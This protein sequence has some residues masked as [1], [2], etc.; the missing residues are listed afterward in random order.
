MYM[1][2]ARLWEA[3]AADAGR[4]DEFCTG[5]DSVKLCLTKG[6]AAPLGGILLKIFMVR[7]GSLGS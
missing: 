6:I 3:V 2:G 4:L 5:E 7:W 1:D